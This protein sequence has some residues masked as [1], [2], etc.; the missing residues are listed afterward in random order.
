MSPREEGLLSSKMLSR[1]GR[2]LR[3][4]SDGDC[5]ENQIYELVANLKMT[6]CPV[7]CL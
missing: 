4:S 3:S 7:L 2:S 1:R 6:L 5:F